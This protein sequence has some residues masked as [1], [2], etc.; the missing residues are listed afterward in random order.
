MRSPV[1]FGRVLHAG[2]YEYARIVDQDVQLA[3]S[4]HRR[5]DG[6]IPLR[7]AGDVQMDVGRAAAGLRYLSFDLF[8]KIVEDVR[9]HHTRALTGKQL[10]L[11]RALT[12]RSAADQRNFAF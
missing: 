1:L 9:Y 8:A 5:A 2:A 4:L 12:S 3:V 6:V 10:R 11:D 7:F